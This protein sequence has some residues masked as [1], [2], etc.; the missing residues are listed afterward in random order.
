M[1]YLCMFNLERRS[2]ETKWE[3]DTCTLYIV[4]YTFA[5]EWEWNIF[6]TLIRSHSWMIALLLLHLEY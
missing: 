3:M 1:Q 5:E 6:S 4:Q 2:F